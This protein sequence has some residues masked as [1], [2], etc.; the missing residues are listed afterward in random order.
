MILP[1]EMNHHS[2]Y[3][4]H[5]ND[6]P[7]LDSNLR[8]RR[9]LPQRHFRTNN[10][11]NNNEGNLH[12]RVP[13]PLFLFVISIL[14]LAGHDDTNGGD[15]SSSGIFLT[16]I[17][18]GVTVVSMVN[19][20]IP[21]AAI[22]RISLHQPTTIL[23]RKH[24]SLYPNSFVPSFRVVPMDMTNIDDG[25]G[26]PTTGSNS[27]VDDIVMETNQ[28]APK[29]VSTPSL[30]TAITMEASN[31]ATTATTTT[32]A[33]AHGSF[34]LDRILSQLTLGFPFFVV[35]FAMM[36]FVYPSTLL[37]IN[38]GN[39]VTI[40]LALVMFG[41][42]LTLQQNDFRQIWETKTN[43]YSVVLGVL[44]QFIIMPST[45]YIVGRFFFLSHLFLPTG[46]DIASALFL[47]LCF[48]GCSPGGTASNVVTYIAN[49]NVALS[50]VLTSCSTFAAVV[51]T[52]LLI[53]LL[54]RNTIYGSTSIRT[55]GSTATAASSIQISG[56]S[57][58]TSTAK[59]VLLPI[60]MGMIF[61]T[62]LPA[63]TKTLC[64]FTPF[65]SV[66]FVSMICGGVVAQTAAPLL[67]S[68]MGTHNGLFP[69][70]L[71]SVLLLHIIGFLAGYIV[72]KVMLT[73]NDG[74]K[75]SM[76]TNYELT[77]RTIS[78]EVGMQ[79]SAL[80]VVLA[81]SI[82]NLHPMACLPGAISAT[83][84]SCLG[85]ILAAIWRWQSSQ[86]HNKA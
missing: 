78:I 61:K 1:L 70:I 21:T 5:A 49:A 51:V 11:N 66:L 53:Q 57:L 12:G 58:C 72:P 73:K 26:D 74:N 82:P 43:R 38:R 54:L 76:T 36:G 59:V 65:L 84:H 79:N 44:C 30:S 33:T 63:M 77:A 40:L 68:G 7:P 52:P 39:T 31:V 41:T 10:N 83:V 2:T 69:I 55:T 60:I 19:A 67:S 4:D 50:V 25:D 85:S 47:G 80:A 29:F 9:D 81:R 16:A 34:T 75:E 18:D 37:W 20:F 86:D 45:A 56:W 48:V 13:L 32:T 22:T 23:T 24:F 14:L 62:R 3:H 15:G 8:R 27:S 46:N 71:S 28:D 17:L 64:R 42:G 6:R 35:T